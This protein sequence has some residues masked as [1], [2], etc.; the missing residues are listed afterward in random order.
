MKPRISPPTDREGEA[1]AWHLQELLRAK[2][3]E[4]PCY[5]VTY[6]EITPRAVKDAFENPTEIDHHRVDAQQA[7]GFL[8]V[9]WVIK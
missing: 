8:T 4:F 6:N 3:K 2:N 9:L 7:A 1:I 5:R